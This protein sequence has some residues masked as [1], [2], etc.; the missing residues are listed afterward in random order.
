M[1]GLDSGGDRFVWGDGLIGYDD[2]TEVLWGDR[3]IWGDVTT[4]DRLVWG[5][6]DDTL[7]GMTSVQY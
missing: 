2:G 6:L 5:D 7:A 1:R 4:G 3:F